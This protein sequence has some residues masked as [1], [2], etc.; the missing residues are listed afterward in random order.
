MHRLTT[1]V[2]VPANKKFTTH[3]T[4]FHSVHQVVLAV[5]Y[6]LDKGMKDSKKITKSMLPE[7]N[8]LM[9]VQRIAR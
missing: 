7:Y 1:A 9:V 3:S 4:Q 8:D 6:R 2:S 5:L